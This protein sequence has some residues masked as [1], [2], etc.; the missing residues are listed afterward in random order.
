MAVSGIIAEFNPLHSG[1]KYIIDCA[2]G[3]ENNTV[4]AVISSNFVQRGDTAIISKQKR[5]EAAL[6]CGAD[7]VAEL[8]VLWSMSTAQNFAL[9]G[10][11]QLYAL[12]CDE[13][14]F[15]SECGDI[16]KLK[17]AADILFSDEFHALAAQNVSSG[18]TF[19]AARQLAAEQLGIDIGLLKNPNDNL[20]I[21]YICAAKQLNI[22]ISFRC[23]KR[24]GA[25]HDEREAKGGYVSAS[26][27]REHLMN[28]SIGFVERYMP[29]EL[30]GLIKPE[31][32]SDI[33]RLERAI[34]ATL[35]TKSEDELK[36]LP[37]ISEGIENKLFFSIR[38]ADGLESLYNMIKTKRYTM[39]RVRRLVLSAFLGFDKEF[40]MTSPPYVRVL[41]FS[42]KGLS[43]LKDVPSFSPIV[44]RA[45][46]I[47]ES[48]SA[49]NRVF[50]AECR[51]TDLYALSFEK[52]LACG[53]EYTAKLLKT[54]D[55]VK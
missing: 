50:A 24:V 37:D 20:G 22:P 30:R 45:A 4:I 28:G 7:I 34:L 26:L 1:H 48:G 31:Y 5:A 32:I 53:G 44:T 21:E 10:V 2:R 3:A 25:G 33:S 23:V 54:E 8:P 17:N 39:A 42:Q 55:L 46:Q 51:A 38:R 16:E 11:W 13:I 47:K 6:L 49:A 18:I 35:R 14:V 15:G 29:S 27:I 19:A 52:P 36:C 43:H 9:G 12:G 40:F 41:G